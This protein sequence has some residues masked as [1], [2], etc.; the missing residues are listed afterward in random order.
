MRQYFDKLYPN[1]Q[2]EF[3]KVLHSNL[4]SD[5]KTF[6]ITANPETLMI[7]RDNKEFNRVLL[8]N[9][10]T[11]VPDG[12]GIVKAARILGYQVN[13]RVTGVEIAAFLLKDAN[14][15]KKSVYFLGAEKRVVET[16]VEKIMKKYADIV[17][18]GF[19]DGYVD[20]KDYV[21]REIEELKPDIILV[22]LGI[23]QQ[24]LLISRNIKSFEKGIFVGVGGSFDVLSGLKK[25]A[26][27]IF[28]KFNLE[29]L[30]RIMKEPWRIKRF[31]RNNV[32]FISL[33][34]KMK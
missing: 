9:N 16:L 6:V 15:E 11:I 21:F 34:K 4:V 19:K 10:T 28:I 22:A 25:R 24:E 27:K 1:G 3:E 13:G 14:Q 31:Y 7:G 30:Y 23:P 20:D 12:I 17:I 29:W 2:K 33:I 8:D 18:A 5:K 32:R 26:P